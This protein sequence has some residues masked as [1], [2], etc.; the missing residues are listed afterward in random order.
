MLNKLVDLYINWRVRRERNAVPAIDWKALHN[1][2]A[3]YV[4]NY[5]IFVETRDRRFLPINGDKGDDI[6]ALVV[7]CI[8]EG[9]PPWESREP[10]RNIA[11]K[12]SK[13]PDLDALML[14]SRDPESFVGYYVRVSPH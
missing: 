3:E 8:S 9:A 13:E 14:V 7:A 4:G 5:P 12:L 2:V 1:R 11:E 6:V 10:A